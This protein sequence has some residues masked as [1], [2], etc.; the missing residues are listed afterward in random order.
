MDETLYDE[1]GNYIGPEIES[2]E[3]DS[4]VEEEEQQRGGLG[5]SDANGHDADDAWLANI[6]PDGHVDDDMEMDG[7]VVLAEDKKYYPTA[8]EVSCNV[9]CFFVL[10]S[11]PF[12]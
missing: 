6:E 5:R 10:A 8:M 9:I 1:F 2:D 11:R 4:D 7:A 12:L 3:D